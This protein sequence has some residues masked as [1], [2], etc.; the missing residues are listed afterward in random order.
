MKNKIYLI[1]IVLLLMI[2]AV[3]AAATYGSNEYGFGKYGEG[4]TASSSP[5]NGGGGGGGVGGSSANVVASSVVISNLLSGAEAKFSFSDDQSSIE[6]INFITTKDLK[7]IKLEIIKLDK[8][9]VEKN[10]ALLPITFVFKTMKIEPTAFD[11]AAIKG[12]AQITFE[13]DKDWLTNNKVDKKNIVMY[14]FTEGKWKALST[15]LTDEKSAKYTYVANTP[16]FS[17]FAIGEKEGVR[18][19]TSTPTIEP[20]PSSSSEVGEQQSDL[21]PAETKKSA[22][23]SIL[24]I[25]IVVVIL[26]LAIG[27]YFL[28]VRKKD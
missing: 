14:H 23:T 28:F 21:Q 2:N 8:A 4:Y 6:I 12:E 9:E 27:V 24:P 26:L 17:Y 15:S 3:Y 20:T 7:N 22:V 11:N 16:G 13:V 18:P 19:L 1:S 25:I 10:T 5:G